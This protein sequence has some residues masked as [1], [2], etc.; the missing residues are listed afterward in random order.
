MIKQTK[1]Q[2]EFSLPM[3]HGIH[4]GAIRTVLASLIMG[5]ALSLSHGALVPAEAMSIA[6]MGDHAHGELHLHNE[7]A[8]PNGGVFASQ[9][10]TRGSKKRTNPI[11]D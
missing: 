9:K 8:V 5:M 1:S 2:Y 10:L 11:M 6:E 3:L 7:L 4:L